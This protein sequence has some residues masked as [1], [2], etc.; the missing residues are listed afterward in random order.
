M[1]YDR[2][3]S[4]PNLTLAWHRL[5][6]GRNFQHKRFFRHLYTSYELGLEKNVEHLH[7]RLKANWQPTPPERIYVPK[8]SGLLRPL[9]ML[10]V[11]DQIV[12]QAVA[13]IV[14]LKVRPRRQAV[15]NRLVFSNCLN[16]DLNSIHFL[17][18]WKR[19][20][21]TFKQRMKSLLDQG[22]R[23]TTHFDLA[24]YYDTISHKLLVRIPS[25]RDGDSETW[26]K[27]LQWLPIWTAEHRGV[28]VDHGIPQGPIASDF[29]AD[30]FLLPL[31]KEMSSGPVRYVRYVD[32]IRL[33]A[34]S[35]EAVREASIRLEMGSR[36][37]GLIPQSEKFAIRSVRKLSDLLGSLPSIIES[38]LPAG[39]DDRLSV[40]KGEK[41]FA[42]SLKGRP[43][44][45]N[46]KS[47]ARFA[48]YRTGRSPRML[49]QVLQMFSHHPE[50]VDA[51]V[52][53]LSNYAK[54]KPIATCMRQFLLSGSP[55]DYVRGQC[56][57]IVARMG[58][59]KLLQT[60]MSRA[61]FDA[62]NQRRSVALQWG[63]AAF[64]MA[65]RRNGLPCERELRY[66]LN[67]MSCLGKSL[68]AELLEASDYEANG[69]A[70]K[71]LTDDSYE[72]GLAMVSPFIKYG[73][74]PT[75]MG[76]NSDS[77]P[78]QV[79]NVLATLNMGAEPDPS[80]DQ[81]GILLSRRFELS[82]WMKWR[83]VLGPEYAHALSLLIR[84][85]NLYQ[86]SRSDW[87][88]S[89]N[90]FNDVL[91]RELL[92]HL[93]SRNLMSEVLLVDRNQKLVR[94]GSLTAPANPF[95]TAFPAIGLPLHRCNERR[96]RLPDSHAYDER[97][98]QRTRYLSV[99]EQRTHS[100]Q[101][102]TCYAQIVSLLD[103][104]L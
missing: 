2:L 74:T 38:S 56:W 41:M 70:A 15:E 1:L 65:C 18:N 14:A 96:N 44:R 97:T 13:N 99:K 34:K 5:N 76:I 55:Y 37:L 50:H 42:A 100:T 68:V 11:E 40:G 8:S 53:F 54:S 28:R 48:L 22:Y 19:G 63:L 35:E 46:S 25:P 23:W 78:F 89:L 43:K 98:G 67:R 104:L 4:I 91:V 49:G 94:L 59:E 101:L 64:L 86:S 71:L 61:R 87:L 30:A 31:D 21:A 45:I 47:Q 3:I 81:V 79:R 36:K 16:S 12:Y 17:Q 51:F 52:A 39:D 72:A 90:S 29:L 77:L 6:T 73:V 75:M 9:T 26:Q 85:D 24:A 66:L 88:R 62:R 27:V 93:M 69:L 10:S 103:P 32:D 83:R 58:D 57:H 102:Q 60:L 7:Q 33:L 95:S 82:A 84:A 20:Y 92:K 80:I